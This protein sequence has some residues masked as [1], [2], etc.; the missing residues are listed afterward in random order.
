MK[1]INKTSQFQHGN[2]NLE[3]NERLIA[4]GILYTHKHT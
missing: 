3:E 4:K 2:H 1:V